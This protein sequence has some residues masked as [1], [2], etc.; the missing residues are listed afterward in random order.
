MRKQP[1][2]NHRL[3]GNGLRSEAL[4]FLF[5]SLLIA[6]GIFLRVWRAGDMLVF[7]DEIHLLQCVI[8]KNL[9]W[10]VTHFFSADACIP[11][12]VY[13][14][15]LLEKG[16]LN[17]WLMRLPSYSA[18]AVILITFGWAARKCLRPWEG[19]FSVG[20]FSL[21]PYFIFLAREA[22][23][24]AIITL[25]FGVAMLCVFAWAR[26]GPRGLLLFS[27]VLCALAIY[28]HLV[29]G[30]AV[31]ALGLYPLVMI[32]SG[33]VS[34]EKWR[35]YVYSAV[36]FLIITLVLVGPSA[37][38]LLQE[39]GGKAGQG[40]GGMETIQRGLM[41]MHGLPVVIP[42]WVWA[43]CCAAGAWSLYRR[44]SPETVCMSAIVA[45]Q[46]GS[47]WLIEPSYVEIPWVWLRYSAHVYPIVVV[48]VA[49]G[50]ASV[51]RLPKR[52][53]WVSMSRCLLPLI[54]IA[55]FC[56][57][58]ILGNYSLRG[59]QMYNT[60]PMILFAPRELDD[61]GLGR[62]I[63]SFYKN[64]L[65]SLPPGSLIEVPMLVTFP[66]YRV[67]Q[68]D[69]GRK[70]ISGTLGNGYGQTIFGDQAVT[71]FKTN[72]PVNAS[73]AEVNRGA[74]YLIIHKRIKTE[75]KEAFDLLRR[76]RLMGPQIDTMAYFFQIPMLDFL[77]G[78]KDLGISDPN[79]PFD[80]VYEDDLVAVYDLMGT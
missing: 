41:L 66:L 29:V 45:I 68:I 55:F 35:D 28:F 5:M 19:L 57:H 73:I 15:L 32:A 75:L 48:F 11:L 47:I 6:T 49:G 77:F 65:P 1:V 23:P 12:A 17:E 69:H 70:F 27:S 20:L 52:G 76:D 14:K 79:W 59:T 54:L 3:P 4:M 36:I 80:C 38:S 78:E 33:R 60:H 71:R 53:I 42:V 13:C 16:I 43:L 26:G 46:M 63:P 34:R 9:S 64:R 24:Y 30:P 10:I 7:A 37:H 61:S 58:L 67:Y 51:A 22:R 25:L 50:L 2:E 62:I 8:T 40:N 74:R 18:G 56:R 39:V 44:Y 72:L 21:S 31:A